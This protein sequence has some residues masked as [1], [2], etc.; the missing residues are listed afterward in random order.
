[1]STSNTIPTSTIQA[2]GDPRLWSD[3]VRS[4][5]RRIDGAE[6]EDVVQST[7]T[8]AL[9]A[10]ALPNAVDEVR[11]FV[12]AIARQKT[13]DVHRRRGR[14]QRRIEKSAWALVHLMHDQ[15][16]DTT[17]EPA[18]GNALE[19]WVERTLPEAPA[20]KQTLEWML[21]EADGETLSEI[22]AADRVSAV[23][24]RQRVSRLRRWFRDRWA[25]ELAGT[26]V[27]LGI[28]LVAVVAALVAHR[29]RP[30]AKDEP[31]L[32]DPSAK[33]FPDPTPPPEPK[34]AEMT[35]KSVV[36]VVP[37]PRDDRS[38]HASPPFGAAVPSN[39]SYTGHLSTRKWT[40]RSAAGVTDV[41]YEVTLPS[42]NVATCA[43][44]SSP[45]GVDTITLTFR[46]DGS[47]ERAHVDGGTAVGR[48]E[49]AC[50]ER[51]YS[52]LVRL[53]KIDDDVVGPV[54]ASAYFRLVPEAPPAWTKPTDD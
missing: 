29:A 18:A 11:P 53:H 41:T 24:V 6:V 20:A 44:P 48:P 10:K 52:S 4:V 14:E 54:T 23:M 3:L 40:S 7:L 42:V 21:R 1:M 19:S 45:R 32:Q 22:A 43:T 46:R 28:I 25:K 16:I 38:G 5:R 30:V 12:F 2:L 31:I 13:A 36:P 27:A 49:A 9:A 51:L 15:T 39:G 33:P 50:V 17:A 35:P 26:A 47:V 34:P 37:R 8:E